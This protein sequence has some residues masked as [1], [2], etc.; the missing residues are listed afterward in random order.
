MIRSTERRSSNI[1]NSNR[2]D[3]VNCIIE[4]CCRKRYTDKCSKVSVIFSRYISNK[5]ICPAKK[6]NHAVFSLSKHI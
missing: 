6:F 3:E 1:E 2:F 5:P 4:E